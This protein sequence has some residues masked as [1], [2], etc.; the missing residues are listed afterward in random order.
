MG[1][2]FVFVVAAAIFSG[3]HD[4]VTNLVNVFWCM[5][6]VGMVCLTDFGGEEVVLCLLYIER[7]PCYSLVSSGLFGSGICGERDNRW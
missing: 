2:S 4:E 7:D 3:K 6:F 5:V 1:F